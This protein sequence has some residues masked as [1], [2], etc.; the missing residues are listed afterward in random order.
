MDSTSNK[1]WNIVLEGD[2]HTVTYGRAGTEGQTKSKS[3]SDQET[4]RRD[5]EKLIA[6]KMKKGYVDADSATASTG[7]DHDSVPTLAFRSILKS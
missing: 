7:D 4:A 1:F 3:F 6:A 2:S 5:Y